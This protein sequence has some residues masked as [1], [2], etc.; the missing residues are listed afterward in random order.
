MESKPRKKSFNLKD[1]KK[2]GFKGKGKYTL[3]GQSVF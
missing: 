3:N 1:G 2:A